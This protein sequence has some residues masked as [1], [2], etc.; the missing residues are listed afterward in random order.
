MKKLFFLAAFIV[1]ALS[2][3]CKKH[4]T[5]SII[6]KGSLTESPV[7]FNE[8]VG[9][10]PLGAMN[11]PS[12]T[13]PTNHMYFYYKNVGISRNIKSPGNLHIFSISRARHHVGNP[14]ETI[15][16][17][18]EFGTKGGTELYFYHLYCLM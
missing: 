13:F 17:I 7:N 8:F 10:V 11:P 9:L 15:D 1:G 4:P 12:H 6:E 14:A 5:E 18:I 16:F 2:T 3:G